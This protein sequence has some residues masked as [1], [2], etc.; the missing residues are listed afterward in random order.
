[1]I[2][3]IL[4]ILGT[5]IFLPWIICT[6]SIPWDAKRWHKQLLVAALTLELITLL[7]IPLVMYWGLGVLATAFVIYLFKERPKIQI[8]PLLVIA[9]LY[10]IWYAISLL[11]SAAPK[12]GLQFLLDNGLVI[13]GFAFLAC[14]I[15]LEKEEYRQVLQQFCYASCIFI[16]LGLISWG[17]SCWQMHMPIWE[18]PILQKERVHGISSFSWVFRF[19]GG[20]DG[21]VH[22]SYNMLPIFISIPIA[23]WLKKED[24]SHYSLW[25]FLWIGGLALTLLTQS[26]MGIIYSGIT[27]CCNVVFLLNGLRAK[28]HTATGILVF[29]IA[30]LACSYDFW[31]DYSDDPTRDKLQNYT[32]QYIKQKPILGAGAGALNPIE[33]CHANQLKYWPGVGYIDPNLDTADWKTKTPMIA[34]NQWIA[35]WAHAG[36]IA[37]IITTLLYYCVILGCIKT[38]NYWGSIFMLIFIIFS[39]LEPPLYIGKGLYL[40]CLLTILIHMSPNKVLQGE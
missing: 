22:P 3:T 4:T 23:A 8:T 32:W 5:S 34:H 11:W 14:S 28:I 40:F 35:D 37:F 25:C 38:R 15:K 39:L 18:W 24:V 30:L 13:V 10:L 33:I 21:Y 6:L 16:V 12:R 17:I 26:R 1:M 19:L 9:L 2:D 36:I 20:L 7:Y 29:G 27:L 31:D